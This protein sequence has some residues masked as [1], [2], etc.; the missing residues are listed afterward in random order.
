MT[1]PPFLR[2]LNS[3]N[4]RLFFL[5]Q[6]ASLLGNWMSL[7]ALS[8]LAYDLSGS[9]F[10]LG[11]LLFANQIPVL[12]L[13]PVAGVWSDR[14]NRR[15]LLFT[16]NLG[17]AAQATALVIVTVTGHATVGWLIALA[18]MRGLLNAVEFPSRQSFLIEIVESKADLPNAIALNSSMFNIARLLGPMIAGPL[19]VVRGPTACFV[20]DALSYAPILGSLLAMRLPLRRPPAVLA[21]PFTELRAG[22][23]YVA[24]IPALRAS[25]FMVAATAFA[26]FTASVLAPVFARDVF[27]A[28]ARV[29]GRFYS[30]MAVGALLS[31]AFL[32]TRA[33]A[34]GLGRWVT[35]GAGLVVVSMSGF[36]LS[37]SLWFAFACLVINGMGTVLIMA[38][39]NTLLQA[40]V[41][42]DKRGRV[43]GLFVM[44]QGTYP[45]GS[46]AAGGI[47]NVFGPHVAVG[48]CAAFM[49]LAALA[50]SRSAAGRVVTAAVV[51]A[52]PDARPS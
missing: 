3:R 21:H 12:L 49:A 27:H 10:V 4:Y 37:T 47:A 38:G 16:A 11:L 45:L 23:Q 44:C 46:L 9:A 24:G 32:S 52:A 25:L 50:F 43:M 33:T 17:C 15:R 41:H 1:F 31:G 30:A 8:W 2:A 19:I 36:A 39:N 22:L 51:T 29:L 7:T 48:L 20:A 5:G 13:A 26:G 14:T 6:T 42:D 18:A 35:R 40:S 34:A 28:D